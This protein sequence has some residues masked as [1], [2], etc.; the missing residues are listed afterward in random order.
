M[1]LAQSKLKSTNYAVYEDI[2]KELYDLRKA[3]CLNLKRRREEVLKQFSA[4]LSLTVY[5]LMILF[6]FVVVF[7]YSNSYS[8]KALSKIM[9]EQFFFLLNYDTG[10]YF[11][12]AVSTARCA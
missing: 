5:I 7:I 12:I 2:P 3:Q 1:E 10:R 8:C 4:K 6:H 11:S 9:Q